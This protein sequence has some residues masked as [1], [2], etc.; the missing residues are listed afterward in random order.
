MMVNNEI[1]VRQPVEEIGKKDIATTCVSTCV[2]QN[3]FPSLPS[4]GE[5]CRSKRVF[6]HTDAAQVT[7]TCHSD[8][9]LHGDDVIGDCRL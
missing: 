6:F 1:G 8:S 4:S 7:I 5:L 3:L 9:I 2:Y